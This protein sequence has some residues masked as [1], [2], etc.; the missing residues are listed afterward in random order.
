M[1]NRVAIRAQ[2][3]RHIIIITKNLFLLLLQMHLSFLQDK[4]QAWLLLIQLFLTSS[5]C[6]LGIPDLTLKEWKTKRKRW[7]SSKK[8]ILTP[9]KHASIQWELFKEWSLN[10]PK[11]LILLEYFLLQREEKL[12]VD[13]LRLECIEPWVEK[14]L[15][16]LWLGFYVMFPDKKEKLNTERFER[17]RGKRL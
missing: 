6:S 4:G 15:I 1:A 8:T 17:I 16:Q 12:W 5:K 3:F 14:L 10:F 13:P 9:S 11:S 2:H 7:I